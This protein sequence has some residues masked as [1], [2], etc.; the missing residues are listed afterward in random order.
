MN[1]RYLIV[2]GAVLCAL[3]WSAPT[4]VDAQAYGSRMGRVKQGG[5][6][7]FSPQGPGILFDALDPAVRKWYVPQELYK[8]YQWRQ[9]EYSNYAREPYQRYVDTALEGDYF[10]D[11]FG[12]LVTRGWLI[13][14]WQQDRPQQ[15]GSSILKTNRF[16]QWFTRVAVSSDHKGQYHYSI[17]IG[18]EIRTTLTPMTFSKPTFNGIQW[19]FA[20]DKYQGTLLLARP[21]RP[22]VATSLDIPDQKTSVTNLLGGRG[23]VQVGDFV[24]V[25]ATYVTA[26]QGQTLFD[27][28]T[29]NPFAGGALTTDQNALPISRII[30]RLSDDSPADGVGG[31]AL[32]DD[33]I[34]IED[35]DGNIFRGSAIG[36]EPIREGGF[37][38]VGFLA[39]D[40]DE[41]ITLTYDFTDPLYTGPDPTTI[42]RVSF[43][44]V[45]SNDYKVEITS[46]RQTNRD[47]QP[48][49]L[50][51]E[52]AQNNIRDNS[53]QRLLQF[54]Y[55]LPTA[56]TILGVTLESNKVWG[57]DFY[58]EYDFNN[59]YRQYP[60][61]NLKDHRKAVNDAQAWMFNLSKASYPWFVFL[62]GYSMDADYSTRTFLA[63]TRGQDE[64][65]YEDEISY[66]YEFVEDNDDQ[67]R[68]PDWNRYSMLSD[69]A[70][71]P[72]FDEN[73]DFVSDFNQN[74]TEDRQ[75]FIPDYE[76]PFLRYHADRPEYLFGVDMNNNGWIDRF[77]NDEEPDYP[78]GRDHRGY[79][80]YA[81][82]QIGPEARLTVGRLREKLLAGDRKNESTYLLFTYERDF[83]QLG[84]LRV[85]DNFKLVEDDIPDNLF[86][87]VQPSNSR[88]TQQRVFDLLPA[89]D[90]WVNT[91]YVQF[92]FTLVGNLNVIN[93]FKTE[94]YNQRRDQRDLRGTASFAGL[95][96][97][98]DYTFPVRNIEL[99]PRFKSEFLRE[100]PV[101]KRDPERRELTET[102]F[103]IARIPM[104]SHT[105]IELGLELSHFEQ[106][107]DDEEGV[108]V[109][110]D[111]EPDSFSRIVAVQFNN[112]SDYL[113]YRLHLQTG[114]RLQKLTFENLPPSTTSKIFMTAYAGLER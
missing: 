96:N 54:D 67:D 59:Q 103:L 41:R 92:D 95:I 71:F 14:D 63:G 27:D 33:E 1:K 62:E 106:F 74:D 28:F 107:R 112:S 21:S 35:V 42:E 56:N 100:R 34:I 110:R 76:E 51:I 10:Y 104:L 90:T 69:N 22:A 52:R 66:I 78:Y 81:G 111:L 17:T 73:N 48:V 19:D 44:L 84:R 15:F 29:G 37:Q 113:G 20:A 31:A 70:V 109:N 94:I 3:G 86:Q 26:F 87:W 80:I 68:R 40:G 8:E 11:F 88:G 58:G 49:F 82:T 77:E 32:F 16:N 45:I 102:L 23:I 105:L 57:F 36:F 89:R 50:L 79:N 55:G 38:R 64:I 85:F 5:K 7:D 25:G 61:L 18:D 97:K 99:E 93:K 30:I 24:Q 47:S 83:A 72:G 39:A 114:F 60:N 65:D 13:Y 43:E 6:V 12:N 101:R 91:S 75:N 98:V 9:W 108:P 53:N 2:V 4:P 46:D